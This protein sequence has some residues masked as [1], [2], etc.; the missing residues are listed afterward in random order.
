MARAEGDATN[1]CRWT[2]PASRKKADISVRYPVNNPCGSSSTFFLFE[3]YMTHCF[4]SYK[5]CTLTHGGARS[6]GF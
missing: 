6:F 4:V 3:V 5:I 1:G 2:S